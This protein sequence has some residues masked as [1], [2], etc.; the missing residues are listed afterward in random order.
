M[1]KENSNKLVFEKGSIVLTK[2]P[3]KDVDV[4]PAG[5]T[6][7]LTSKCSAD[8][9]WGSGQING[10]LRLLLVREHNLEHK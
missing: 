8:K 1:S 9:W 10:V 2:E 3:E 5:T 4:I 7:R 6:I